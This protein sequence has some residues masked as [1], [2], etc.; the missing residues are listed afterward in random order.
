MLSALDLIE[1][2]R[3]AQGNAT[4]YRLAKLLGAQPSAV[5][6]WKAGRSLPSESMTYR[7]AELAGVD[8][9]AAVCWVSIERAQTPRDAEVWQCLLSRVTAT[10]AP[11]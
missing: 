8:P 4:D 11:I 5:C 9:A 6:H 2:A 3:Q 7:L 1:L 10:A